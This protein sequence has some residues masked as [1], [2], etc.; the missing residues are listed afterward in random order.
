[1]LTQASGA[2]IAL[3][4]GDLM[5][6]RARAGATAPDLGAPLDTQSGLSGECVRGG[7]TLVCDDTENDARVNLDVCRYLGIRSIAV[8]PISV[9]GDTV[10]VFEAFSSRPQAF[11]SNELAAL[12]SMRD[13]V[14]SVI[15]P[16]PQSH[17]PA[18]AA[19]NAR[20]SQERLSPL[21]GLFDPEDD[22]MCE[23]EQRPP[24]SPQ[25]DPQRRAFELIKTG[26][27]VAA[28]AP[29]AAPF[30][31]PDP[32]DDLI[33]E[34]ET[35]T[36]VPAAPVAELEHAHPFST[37]APAPVHPAERPVSRK[38]IILGV[39]VALAGLIWLHWCNRA[40]SEAP[41][42]PRAGAQAAA[43]LPAPL[44]QALLA[45][46]WRDAGSLGFL[47]RAR[48]TLSARQWSTN[49]TPAS[50]SGVAD[51]TFGLVLTPAP[52]TLTHPM[53]DTKLA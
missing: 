8:L 53:I 11:S 1:M 6:C 10:G 48:V 27:E 50:Y 52:V 9:E 24:A 31:N 14:I 12:E 28:A 36:Y 18:V 17:N 26:N 44:P 19:L 34:M 7:I 40:Q 46:H 29:A 37:F 2:A 5:R 13:L 32:G 21:A 20:V 39:I 23:L 38:L 49:G 25:V 43:P 35:R 15:R 33:C 22:L 45:A 30:A 42:L 4:E 51:M 3:L 47:T 41:N 16:A